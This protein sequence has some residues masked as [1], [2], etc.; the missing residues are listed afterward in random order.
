MMVAYGVFALLGTL[1]FIAFLVIGLGRLLEGNY[2]LSSLIVAVVCMGV[3]AAMAYRSY[4][5]LKSEDMSLS[6]TQRTLEEDKQ[7]ITDAAQGAVQS[8]GTGGQAA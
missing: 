3:G 5:K 2:W 7:I 6:R 4:S 1:P 8:G